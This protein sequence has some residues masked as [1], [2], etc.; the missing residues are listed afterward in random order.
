MAL[1]LVRDGAEAG[2]LLPPGTIRVAPINEFASTTREVIE[3]SNEVAT[4]PI[5]GPV[6]LDLRKPHEPVTFGVAQMKARSATARTRHQLAIARVLELLADGAF[7]YLRALLGIALSLACVAVA[8]WSC[9]LVAAGA[10][11]CA[12]VPS[13]CGNQPVRRVHPTI[14][15]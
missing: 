8:A 1:R 3:A 10:T 6:Q 14:L 4:W 2:P 15:H 9:G 7:D 13:L 12:C 11:A 5:D